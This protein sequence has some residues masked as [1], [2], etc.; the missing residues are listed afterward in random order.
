M[1]DLVH[2]ELDRH[3]ELACSGR[4]GC[5]CGGHSHS[6]PT[7]IVKRALLEEEADFVAAGQE[8]IIR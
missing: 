6:S 3:F 4:I 2:G 5:L 1:A 8:V 7:V